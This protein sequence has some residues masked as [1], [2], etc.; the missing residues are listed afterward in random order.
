MH[1]RRGPVQMAT[2]IARPRSIRLQSVN[3]Y[4]E[5]RYA[6]E[7]PQIPTTLHEWN[8]FSKLVASSAGL[9]AVSH[10]LRCRPPPARDCRDNAR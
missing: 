8:G 1:L 7:K 4:S 6:A 3:L 2:N 5:S 10:L 9:Y